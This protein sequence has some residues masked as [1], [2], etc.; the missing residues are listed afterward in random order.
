[1]HSLLGTGPGQELFGALNACSTLLPV[2]LKEDNGNL[3]LNRGKVTNSSSSS[4][5]SSTAT[6]PTPT[7][8]SQLPPLM[9]GFLKKVLFLAGRLIYAVATE[10]GV[11]K[12]E[13][14]LNHIWSVFMHAVTQSW[15]LFQDRHIDHIIVCCIYGVCKGHGKNVLFHRII[16]AHERLTQQITSKNPDLLMLM[17][18]RRCNLRSEV[19]LECA[20]S[21][22]ECVQVQ[23]RVEGWERTTTSVIGFY[24]HVFLKR[25]KKVILDLYSTVGVGVAGGTPVWIFPSKYKF[26]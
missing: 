4:S 21:A 9:A 26:R 20:D 1:M 18:R 2:V 10:V 5:S 8:T 7:P 12:E 13:R 3:N 17:L 23:A 14:I 16:D 11:E 25:M 24:N 22:L 6:T 15:W 19:N